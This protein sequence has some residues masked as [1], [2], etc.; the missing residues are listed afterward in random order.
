MPVLDSHDV[1]VESR[2]ALVTAAEE[3]AA[4]GLLGDSVLADPAARLPEPLAERLA[5]VLRPPAPGVGH[6]VVRGLFA[7]FTDPGPT[8][9]HWR[10]T[11]RER[12]A[13]LD[14]A[15]VL[16]AARFGRVFGWTD[17]QD[18]RIVHNIVPSP[19]CEAMQIGSSSTTELAW[20]TEDAFHPDRADL[21]LLVCVRNPDGIGS[22]LS[23]V[24]SAGLDERDIRHLL[25][26]E[27]A[28]LPDDSY[29]DGTAA[30][31]EPVGMA[32][33]WEREGSLGLRYDPS[34]SRL[35]TDDEEFRD[36]YGRLGRALEAGS[37]GVPLAPGDLVVIDNDAA[38][39]GRTAFRPRY[40][41]TDRWLKRILVR[42]PRQRPAR[43]SLEHGYGQ[44]QV[45]AHGGRPVLRV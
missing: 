25:R 32:T 20:H 17:Q 21:L 37:F 26:P 24:S 13:A 11:D 12:C 2:R 22:R 38:V 15:L 14:I 28:I 43:E 7:G 34:Y 4:G 9:L 41:G 10:E 35:L 42:S 18:G 19:G 39:H 30:A 31:R 5:D 23:T 3:L 1:D 44:R 29:E 6:R 36:A 16:V 8:P 27:V 40:D 45:D 33:L